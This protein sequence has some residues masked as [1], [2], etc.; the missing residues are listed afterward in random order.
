LILGTGGAAKAVEFVLRK[1]QIDFTHVSR[2]QLQNS[3]TYDKLTPEV[4]VKNK[5]IINTTPVGMYPGVDEV[6][7]LPFEAITA[8]HFLFDLIYNP[9]KTL[10]LSKGEERGAIL[11]NG[12]E[13][14]V[15][16]AEESWRIWNR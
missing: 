10:F 12:Y 8:D 11:Q 6:L 4:M 3:L 7:P 14:L 13:M 16:Q 5:L 15:C 2:R 9:P 1:N